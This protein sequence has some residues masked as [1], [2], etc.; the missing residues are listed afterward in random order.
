[1]IEQKLN[2][3]FIWLQIHTHNLNHYTISREYSHDLQSGPTVFVF[4]LFQSIQYS[5][6]RLIFLF[7]W[8]QEK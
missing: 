8:K 7:I 6:V 4:F 5:E 2:P 1:M 3:S